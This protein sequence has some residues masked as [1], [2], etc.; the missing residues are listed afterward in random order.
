MIAHWQIHCRVLSTKE[1]GK[2]V[3]WFRHA[4]RDGL[5]IDSISIITVGSVLKTV[6]WVYSDGITE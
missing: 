5:T 3:H 2:G 6:R 4:S 1:P